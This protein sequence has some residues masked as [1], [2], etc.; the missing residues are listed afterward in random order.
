MRVEGHTDNIKKKKKGM[1]N[2][3]L[4][5]LRAVEVTKY[6]LDTGE[7]PKENIYA[8]GFAD[9]RPVA[10]NETADGRA[11]NRRVDIKILYEQPEDFTSVEDHLENQTFQ[12]K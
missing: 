3:E 6:L 12:N 11:M 7:I 1:T 10:N 8:A 4:S 9:T 2:W 5:S